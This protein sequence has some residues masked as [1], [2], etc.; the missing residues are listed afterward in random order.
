M[1]TLTYDPVFDR[2]VVYLA[3]YAPIATLL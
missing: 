2:K 3:P 1:L